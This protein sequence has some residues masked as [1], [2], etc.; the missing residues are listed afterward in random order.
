[1]KKQVFTLAFFMAVVLSGH[2]QQFY[3]GFDNSTEQNQWTKYRLGSVTSYNWVYA[4]TGS[5]SA[6]SNAYHD[7]PM[8]GAVDDWLVSPKLYFT[9]STSSISL[10]LKRFAYSS[11]PDVY[12]GVWVSFGSKDPAGGAYTELADLTEFPAAQSTWADTT[13]DITLLSDSG[14]I[15]I[16]YEVADY[17]WLMLNV[18]NITVDSASLTPVVNIP[19]TFNNKTT[20]IYPNPANDMIFIE[21]SDN[22]N[23][24]VVIINSEGRTIKRF[25]FTDPVN[26]V[27]LKELPDGIY[28]ILILTDDEVN[29]RKFIK[30]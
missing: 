7:Y 2:S 6:P 4:S 21:R 29:V 11:P 28:S 14:Y 15:A 8:S 10:Y 30:N 1:M 24:D 18:D 23:A 5:F 9:G 25:Q 12:Y 26:S 20:M 27:D 16:R 17:A 3:T 13:L 22:K 19:A